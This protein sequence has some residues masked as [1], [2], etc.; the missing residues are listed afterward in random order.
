MRTL[1]TEIA[2]LEAS[3]QA[4]HQVL[5]M[6]TAPGAQPVEKRVKDLETSL[7]FP[8]PESSKRLLE[9]EL[10]KLKNGG[11]MTEQTKQAQQA[12]ALLE[13]KLKKTQKELDR[14]QTKC[15][16]AKQALMFDSSKI[17]S[18]MAHA[19][20]EVAAILYRSFGISPLEPGPHGTAEEAASALERANRSSF[21][22]R[23]L[24]WED[25]LK[26]ERTQRIDRA[27]QQA[28][29]ADTAAQ[30]E[31][32]RIAAA[33]A[34]MSDDDVL[35]SDIRPRRVASVAL[36]PLPAAA[37]AAASG[38][39][40]GGG[41]SS[42]FAAAVV[43]LPDLFAP[44]SPHA[45]AGMTEQ[46]SVGASGGSSSIATMDIDAE[47]ARAA[48]QNTTDGLADEAVDLEATQPMDKDAR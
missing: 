3:I 39:S 37:A 9:L 2:G 10:E 19:N 6:Q 29:Q 16:D 25:R 41:S 1:H 15:H 8:L 31:Y 17:Q 38:S 42:A 11:G 21:F 45:P 46:K 43:P 44:S 7:A 30:Q 47:M 35:V 26:T 12:L 5:N 36:A 33:A 48:A 14:V 34:A 23:R 27:Q 13:E 28:R 24:E 4:Q 32:A 40:A 18:S 20:F 22:V